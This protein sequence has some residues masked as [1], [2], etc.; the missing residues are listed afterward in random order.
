LAARLLVTVVTLPPTARPHVYAP[1]NPN[2]DG[3]ETGAGSF[4]FKPDVVSIFKSGD[5]TYTVRIAP[6]DSPERLNGF[7]GPAFWL[8][9]IAAFSR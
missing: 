7:T 5:A 6:A 4:S 2:P 3:D 9:E 1:S 8:A